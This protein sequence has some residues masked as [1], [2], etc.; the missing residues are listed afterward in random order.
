M[1]NGFECLWGER[2][3]QGPLITGLSTIGRKFKREYKEEFPIIPLKKIYADEHRLLE[4]RTLNRVDFTNQYDR[5]YLC[6]SNFMKYANNNNHNS[7][8]TKHNATYS[9]VLYVT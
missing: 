9:C 5:Q 1:K 8:Y 4:K 6:C 7:T 2:G 3:A